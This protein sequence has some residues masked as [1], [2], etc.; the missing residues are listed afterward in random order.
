KVAAPVTPPAP[1]GTFQLVLTADKTTYAVHDTAVFSATA[2]RDCS[3]FIV[4]VA[5]NGDGTI[6]FP[7]KFQADNAVKAGQVVQLG[8]EGGPFGFRLKDP[9][10]EKV[11]AVC[12]VNG[13]TRSIDGYT[14]DPSKQTFAVIKDFEKTRFREIGVEGA[15]AQQ[16]AA[17]L[18]DYEKQ[19]Q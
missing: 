14:I 16:E 2:S 9:G 3:L 1:G 18:D 10:Q 6:I 7:N 17:G 19:Q 4:N 11:V 5:A 8:A 13:S 12:K 15:A